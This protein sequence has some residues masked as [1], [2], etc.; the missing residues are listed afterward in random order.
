MTI[1]TAA[2]AARLT[3]IEGF[4]VGP[5]ALGALIIPRGVPREDHA[6]FIAAHVAAHTGTGG[7]IVL[8]AKGSR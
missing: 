7:L 5:L 3:R 8:P 1:T 6:A 2:L 4:Q